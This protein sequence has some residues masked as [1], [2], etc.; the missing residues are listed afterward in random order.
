MNRFPRAL[1]LL[2]FALFASAALAQ[3]QQAPSLEGQDLPAVEERL[4]ET[5]LVLEP[6]EEIGSYG[7]TLRGAI[8]GP[9]RAGDLFRDIN[10][11]NLVRFAP[12]TS[13]IT[14]NI[15][16]RFEAN[17]NATEFTFYLRPGMKW[18]DG[19]DYT[20]DDVVFV[21]EAILTNEELSPGGPGKTLTDS[22]GQTGT[23]E[24]V[25]DYTVTFTFAEP[26]GLF[27]THM[28]ED[29]GN[30]YSRFPSHYL[31]QYHADYNSDNIDSL[32]SDAGASGWVELFENMGGLVGGWGQ[33]PDMPTVTA[34]HLTVP[35]GDSTIVEY[36]RNPYYWKVDPEGNQLPY[37]DTVSYEV[38]PDNEVAVLRTSAGEIDMMIGKT[39]YNSINNKAVLFDNM[40]TGN[41]RFVNQIKVGQANAV[42]S[43]N[44][45]HDDPALREVF[46]N[47]DFRIALSHALDRDTVIE[48]FYVGQA[49]PWQSAP[50]EQSIFYNEQ[51]AKQYTEYDVEEANS[52]LDGIYPDKNSDGIRLGADGEP[53]S[54]VLLV[55]AELR[56]EYPDIAQQVKDNW[57]EVGVD[58]QVSIQ[59][60]TLIQ[61][62]RESNEYDAYMGVG[63]G[64]IDVI[65]RADMYVASNAPSIGSAWSNEWAKWF[66]SDGASGEEPPADIRAS[67]DLYKQLLASGDQET[68]NELMKQILQNA[69]D[70]FY[71][72][73]ISIDNPDLDYGIASNDLRN[74]PDQLFNSWGFVMPG[75]TNPEQFFL[76]R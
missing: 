33:F 16:E 66:D 38:I 62:R 71:Q 63:L 9:A 5:P 36:Q 37:I 35:F 25:D 27:L 7:G 69:A 32:V 10:Y 56:V 2:C 34:W 39:T 45:T 47:K 8:R 13:G 48:T 76:T 28:A 68:Q 67:M 72:I 53:I 21:Y 75:S 29:D 54:F 15:A 14:P 11:E 44:L 26:H 50:R 52:I 73:G 59:D 70:G 42:L 17:D 4:P 74:V 31:S 57:R 20:A 55:P 24:K 40:E 6:V 64:G 22:S 58:V 1:Y 19:D 61:T 30:V 51:L 46:Q 60:E 23:V 43:L 18:S 3:Y 41:Y 12:D 65:T 49:Q